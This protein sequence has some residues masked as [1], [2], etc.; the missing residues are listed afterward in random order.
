MSFSLTNPSN[1]VPTG[2]QTLYYRPVESVCCLAE[3]LVKC[4][5]GIQYYLKGSKNAMYNLIT[6]EHYILY[7]F[8]NRP[9][10][11]EGIKLLYYISMYV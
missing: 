6:V 10:P 2:I 1:L 7:I 11:V 5:F 3:L 4:S 8:I 9:H